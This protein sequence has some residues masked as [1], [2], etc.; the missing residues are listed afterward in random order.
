MPKL[1]TGGN[2]TA[3]KVGAV[4]ECVDEGPGT[5]APVPPPWRGLTRS[6]QLGRRP[7]ACFQGGSTMPL[8]Q[9]EA[10]GI[11]LQPVLGPVGG[12]AG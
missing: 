9:L 7:G 10:L 6:R 1:G 12:D 3:P 4:L 8:P 11:G 2:V 5:A